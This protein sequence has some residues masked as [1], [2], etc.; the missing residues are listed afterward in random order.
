MVPKTSKIF[1]LQKFL[2]N[3]LVSTEDFQ[4]LFYK[5]F[6]SE[7]F[8][9]AYTPLMWNLIALQKVLS[10]FAQINPF[11][12]F[13]HFLRIPI[14]FPFNPNYQKWNNNKNAK[15]AL[16]PMIST[17][18]LSSKIN[19]LFSSRTPQWTWTSYSKLV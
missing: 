18:Y 17:S 9:S 16:G 19:C 6:I 13:L 8:Y 1:K 3:D 11:L 5:T 7:L 10:E 14:K 4:T 15:M 12:A 2:E